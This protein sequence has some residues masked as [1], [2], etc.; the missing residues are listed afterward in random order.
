MLGEAM[1]RLLDFDRRRYWLVNGWSIRLRI[2][3]V[4][5]SAP[6][7]HGIKYAFTLHGQDGTRA[8]TMRMESRGL[9]PTII[10]IASG[11]PGSSSRTNFVAR[12]N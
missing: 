10:G 6:R 11:A 1:R 4:E 3:E 8:S 7:P 9:R 2:M 12:T 5:S